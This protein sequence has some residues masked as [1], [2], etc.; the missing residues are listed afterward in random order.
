MEKLKYVGHESQLFGV[1]EHRLLGGKGDG[2]RLFQVKNGKGI[3]FT[4]SADRGAD[5]SRLSFK[6]DNFSY[7]S[8]NGY[9]APAYYDATGIGFLKS[10]TAGFLT[11]CGLTAVGSP[12]ID[13]GEALPLHGNYNNI[14]AE[15]IY[16]EMDE[17]SIRVHASVKDAGIFCRKLELNR[18][19]MCSKIKNCIIIK[20][21]IMNHG[22]IA[23]PLMILYHMNIGYPLLSERAKL[24]IS[25]KHVIARNEHAAK[26]MDT[27]DQ[28]I[29][30]TVH[31]EEQCY[32]HQFEKEGK[33]AI[34][35]PDIQKG[36]LITFDTATLDYFT[37]WKMMGVHDYVLGLEPGNCHPDGRDKMRE[38]GTLKFIQ[39]EESITYQVKIEMLESEEE[40]EQVIENNKIDREVIRC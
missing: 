33:A 29:E 34:F 27:W 20:D 21:K 3:E 12:C 13:D 5:I 26:D 25:S 2:M 4:V 15:H 32:Y 6:G 1:E 37:E 31:F 35:N 17:E 19:I 40:Y 38:E 14:P 22:D 10:F 30:P 36:L 16:W 18:V 24:H 28:M 8:P 11:T 39:P 23:S 7:F 9:V